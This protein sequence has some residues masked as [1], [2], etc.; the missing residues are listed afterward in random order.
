MVKDI[1]TTEVVTISP[2]TSLKEVGEIL[3]EK[4]VSGL[5]VVDKDGSVVG[6]ITLTDMLRILDQIYHWREIE[7]RVPEIKPS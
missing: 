5:P 3:R 2:E 7:R 1:M 6:I 4:R